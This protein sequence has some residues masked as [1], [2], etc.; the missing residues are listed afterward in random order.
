MSWPDVVGIAGVIMILTAYFLHQSGRLGRL[1]L[2]YQVLNTLGATCILFSLYFD[3]NLSAA[4]VEGAWL[5]I[6]LYGLWQIL[7]QRGRSMGE[8]GV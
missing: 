6:S 5:V 1:H 3:F 7:R 8:P 4:L 2:S